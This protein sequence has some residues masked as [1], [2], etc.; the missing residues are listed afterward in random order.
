MLAFLLGDCDLSS[1]GIGCQSAENSDVALASDSHE[2]SCYHGRLA[3]CGSQV[4]LDGRKKS[5]E[6]RRSFR[7]KRDTCTVFNYLIGTGTVVKSGAK[8]LRRILAVIFPRKYSK[9]Y[10]CARQIEGQ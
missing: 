9:K 8:T 7:P 1:R 6:V 5:A 3:I 10:S 4:H 2:H